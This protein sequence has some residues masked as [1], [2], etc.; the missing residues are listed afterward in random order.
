MNKVG[1][2]FMFHLVGVV[3]LVSFGETHISAFGSA[4]YFTKV[5]LVYSNN[6]TQS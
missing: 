5:G 1:N 6:V 2:I 3:K 4:S